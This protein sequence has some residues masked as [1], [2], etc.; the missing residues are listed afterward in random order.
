V[1]FG[2]R[3]FFMVGIVD[4]PKRP[5]E[6]AVGEAFSMIPVVGKLGKALWENA[7]EW[8]RFRG[9]ETAK[10][11]AEIV[12]PDELYRR[13]QE[14]VELAALLVQVL[15]A[16]ERSGFE[17]KRNLLVMA[18]ANAFQNDEAIDPAVLV[19]RA[20]SQLE[21]V[22]IRALVRLVALSDSLGPPPD[23][24]Q[25]PKVGV[26]DGGTAQNFAAEEA[27]RERAQTMLEAGL[28]IPLPVLVT[29]INTGVVTQATVMASG[30][31]LDDVS[32]FGRQ[33]LRDLQQA[34]PE[35]EI[36][37]WTPPA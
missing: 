35:D 3:G 30:A 32:R 26:I 12:G 8:R 13:A 18:A 25:I 7:N 6:V 4:K 11:I 28:Q 16:A 15:E 22:H 5:V 21:P 31:Y 10:Q 2:V 9:E 24:E 29:L 14:D 27:A 17:A 20:L 23:D 33:L 34:D 19:V 37:S 36:F 1:R